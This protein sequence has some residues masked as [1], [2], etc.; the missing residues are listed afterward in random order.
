M[1]LLHG[2]PVIGDDFRVDP[3]L[4][5]EKGTGYIERD[6]A[7]Y[8]LGGLKC[9][10]M[11]SGSR[12]SLVEIKERIKEKNANKSWLSDKAD[13]VGSKVKNQSSSSYCWIHA[14]VRAMELAYIKQGGKVFTLSAFWPGAR[15]KKGQNQG[16]S[17]IVGVEYLNEHGTCIE[18]MC[19]PLDEAGNAAFRVDKD[20]DHEANALN[21]QIVTWDDIDP[22]DKLAI[23]SAIVDDCAVT[24]GIPAWG[25]EV[26]LTF[27][28]LEGDTIREGFDNSWKYTWGN[29]GRGVLSGNKQRFDEAGR[30]G[31][32]EP[33][34]A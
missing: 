27:L 34:A 33:A 18:S 8:P 16:G 31:V 24:V 28:V 3:N 6:Y 1:E 5:G 22:N 23:W 10:K 11:Y 20:P 13:R 32:L 15:I 7:S 2:Y 17:G 29:N 9:A 30:V 4:D 26:A 25:H 12:Y 19:P 14:P 21:H